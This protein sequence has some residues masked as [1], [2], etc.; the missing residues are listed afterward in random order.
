[1]LNDADGRAFMYLDGQLIDSSDVGTG[2]YQVPGYPLIIGADNAA[3]SDNFTGK[4]DDVR[5]YNR[6]L[7][8]AEIVA[9]Q[10]LTATDIAIELD[11][12]SVD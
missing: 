11:K 4:I 6:L 12:F 2:T 3:Q 7:S 9:L 1:M 8:G 5:L 10:A